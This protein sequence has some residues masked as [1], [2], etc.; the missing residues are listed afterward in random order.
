VEVK[1]IREKLIEKGVGLD[2]DFRMRWTGEVSRIEA[3]NDRLRVRQKHP[4]LM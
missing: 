2:K 3:L 1:L 4:D